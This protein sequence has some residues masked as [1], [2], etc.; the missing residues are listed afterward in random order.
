MG[1]F[2][3]T[4]ESNWRPASASAQPRGHCCR[5]MG[6]RVVGRRTTVIGKI[7][8][9]S[10]STAYDF[11]SLVVSGH[12]PTD[13][14]SPSHPLPLDVDVVCFNDVGNSWRYRGRN[15]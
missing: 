15:L 6:F 2:I 8:P 14:T 10:V 4:S 1:L 7:L 13:N 12:V 3:T 5:G 11:F 9:D